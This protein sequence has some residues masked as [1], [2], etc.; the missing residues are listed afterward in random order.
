MSFPR[1]YLAMGG[2]DVQEISAL[3]EILSTDGV[4]L[5]GIALPICG[6]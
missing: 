5:K 4:T 6:C 2:L 1:V 3:V